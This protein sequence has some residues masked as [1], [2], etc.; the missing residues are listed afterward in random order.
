MF[1]TGINEHNKAFN[2]KLVSQTLKKYQT[3][4]SETLFLHLKFKISI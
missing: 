4:T 2:L 1:V 3:N